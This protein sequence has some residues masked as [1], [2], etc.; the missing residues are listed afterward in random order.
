VLDSERE[1]QSQNA[2]QIVASVDATFL[3][4]LRYHH[5]DMARL[6]IRHPV[7]TR[8]LTQSL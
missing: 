6:E 8:I 2:T 4:T 7:V 1:H 3:P 5:P